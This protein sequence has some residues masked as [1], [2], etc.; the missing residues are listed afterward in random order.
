MADAV[1]ARWHGDNYQSRIF[2][3]NALQSLSTTFLR[4]RGHV[5]GDGPK[6]FD[7][8]VVQLRSAGCALRPRSR[9][10]R[11]PSGQ[12]ARAD[13]RAVRLRGLRRSRLH[14]RADRSRCCSGSSRRARRRRRRDR[15]FL[16]P[17]DLPHQGWRS[18]GR[19][20]LRPRPH[21]AAGEARSTAR[22]TAAAWA[23]CAGFGA[24]ISAGEPT[25]SYAPCVG[26][27]RV[28]E[29]HR[30]LDELRSQINLK[31]QVVGV[32]A[33]QRQRFRFPL[34]RAG[35]AAED[36]AAQCADARN[37]AA[38]FAAR[39]DLFVERAGG[40]IHS[41]RSPSGVSLGLR[42]TSSVRR[43]KTRC[44][45]PTIS[46]S[47]ICRTAAT[48]SAISVR[49]RRRSCAKRHESHRV[50]RLILDAH[51]SIAF[52]VRGGA[53]PEVRRRRRACSEGP[54]RRPRLAAR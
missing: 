23:R 52:L 30:S 47:A 7:D 6:A 21:A 44:C 28:I 2:W 22:P 17:H 48:G 50:L 27:L 10:S 37:F 36:A 31:A 3:E 15:S 11:V 46:G 38:A 8:V 24:I 39:K 51:A 20:H 12:V 49:G 41:F 43:L 18:A 5:R 53:R 14:R 1:T 35:A 54:G 42:P 40:R 33:L 26:G 29:G 45:S 34:R 13:G 16:L 32:M 25:M 19:S 4:R 9:L